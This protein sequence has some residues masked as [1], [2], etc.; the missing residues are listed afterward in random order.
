M[1][2]RLTS[3][4]CL[5]LTA[6]LLLTGC[7]KA[8]ERR[9]ARQAAADATATVEARCN[10][11]SAPIGATAEPDDTPDQPAHRR[12]NHPRRSSRPATPLASPACTS[13]RWT[14]DGVQRTY[15]LY[16]PSSYDASASDTAGAQL[17]RL[18]LQRAGAG[19]LLGLSVAGRAR[20]FHRRDAGR[21]QQPAA[22]VPLRPARGRL[23]R[24]LRLY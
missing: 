9:E 10:A 6:S 18:R 14:S 23:C 3:L 4:L 1:R 8:R 19:A 5:A 16:V 22:L 2:I 21:H 12:A 15:R 13:R 20:G 17:P 11:P 24:R 7:E